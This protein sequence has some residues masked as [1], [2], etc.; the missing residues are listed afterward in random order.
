MKLL[1]SEVHGSEVQ[2]LIL[3]NINL[4]ELM[5]KKREALNLD[6]IGISFLRLFRYCSQ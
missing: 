4:I 5:A 6:C 3:N 2:R 1:G